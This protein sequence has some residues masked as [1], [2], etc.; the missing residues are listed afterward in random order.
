MTQAD[1][2][3]IIGSA[4]GGNFSTSRSP[5]SA[6]SCRRPFADGGLRLHLNADVWRV[7]YDAGCFTA[8]LADGTPVEGDALLVATGR[9]PNTAAL[10]LAA[11]RGG[12]ELD[13]RGYVVV[14]EHFRT[15][16]AGV[17]A[18]RRR[19]GTACIHPRFV[20]RPSA[21]A[22][23]P[24][25]RGTCAQRL[26]GSATYTEPQVGRA[27]LMLEQARKQGYHARAVTATLDQVAR[28]DRVERG[29]R[30]LPARKRQTP[31][32]RT[33]GVRWK[34]AWLQYRSSNAARYFCHHGL[35]GH[36]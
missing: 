25:R 23:D 2:V 9:T 8:F 36:R 6:H 26:L 21:A 20:G 34:S 31:V 19:G 3:I 15:N 11:A 33:R 22:R 10:V 27:G 16:C 7:A 24:R 14:D 35:V 13:E 17:Y 18:N 5:T 32:H 1:V 12:I 4:Q 29:T 30:L 28:A